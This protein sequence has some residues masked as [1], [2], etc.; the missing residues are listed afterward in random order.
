MRIYGFFFE[1]ENNMFTHDYTA[2]KVHAERHRDLLREAENARRAKA[3]RT[4]TGKLPAGKVLL[5]ALGGFFVSVG[6]RMQES[7]HVSYND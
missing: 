6:R 3:C 5:V 7:A 4:N 2:V 1:K